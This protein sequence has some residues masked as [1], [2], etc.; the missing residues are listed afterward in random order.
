MKSKSNCVL[1]RLDFDCYTTTTAHTHTHALASYKQHL[2][3]CVQCNMRVSTQICK[4]E[5]GTSVNSRKCNLHTRQM[6]AR[7]HTQDA[8]PPHP[9]PPPKTP[10]PGDRDRMMAVEIRQKGR[11][12]SEKDVSRRVPHTCFHT[13]TLPNSP[14]LSS[15]I[16]TPTTTTNPFRLSPLL[17]PISTPLVTPLPP[18]PHYRI[19]AA[20][21]RR[22]GTL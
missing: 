2:F 18:T 20:A 21:H 19:P 12:C 6:H 11:E 5:P 8:Y 15:P 16:I 22:G 3:V 4:A 17:S 9:P 1:L 13:H 14:L 7:T 10:Q